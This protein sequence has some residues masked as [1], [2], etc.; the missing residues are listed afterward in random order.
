[1]TLD[2]DDP[3]GTTAP[4]APMGDDRF[5]PFVASQLS[6]SLDGAVALSATESREAAL[7]R[8]EAAEFDQAPVQSGGDT[9]GWV[10]LR[11][12]KTGDGTVAGHLTPLSRTPIVAATTS[13]SRV[14]PAVQNGFVFTVHGAGLSGFIVPSDLERHAMRG[15]FYLAIAEIEM[16]LTDVIGAAVPDKVIEELVRKSPGANRFKKA[17]KEGTDTRIVEYLDLRDLLNVYVSRVDQDVPGPI[18]ETMGELPEFR[19]VIMHATKPLVVEYPPGRLADL[20]A[21]V[22]EVRDYVCKTVENVAPR[23]WF[24]V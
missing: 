13:L 5:S 2:A 10:H 18:S 22:R 3:A 23:G 7:E 6:T 11:D 20:D 4:S 9:V 19:N 16:C 8:L 14:L 21:R 1:M 17:R 24:G 15:H 12:L